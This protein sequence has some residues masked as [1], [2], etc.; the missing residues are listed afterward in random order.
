MKDRQVTLLDEQSKQRFSVLYAAVVPADE[1]HAATSSSPAPAAPLKPP[2]EIHRRQDF[3]VGQRVSFSDQSLK[4][5]VGEI[6]RINQRT[7]TVHCDGRAWRVAFA[8]LQHVTDL[9][10]ETVQPS[11]T[12]SSGLLRLRGALLRALPRLGEDRSSAVSSTRCWASALWRTGI[13]KSSLPQ[14]Y[15][16][17]VQF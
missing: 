10:P 13:C 5:H 11:T 17:G 3:R 8:L 7:A 15:C 16:A 14:N 1:Q 4:R 12:A 6:V 9:T 2:P